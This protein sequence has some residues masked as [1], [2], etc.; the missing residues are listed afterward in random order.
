MWT[1]GAIR[2]IG[3]R[4]VI[5]AELLCQAVDIHAGERVLDVAAGSGNAALA[6]ARRGASVTAS[7]IAEAPL[8]L[9]RRRADLEGLALNTELADAQG[10]PF[11]DGSFDVVLSTFG[12]MFAPNQQRVADELTR[13][14]RPGGRIGL[15]N[16]TPRG[17][18]GSSFAM[19]DQHLPQ[20]TARL[21]RT[22]KWGTV[23]RLQ[24][25]LGDRVAELHTRRRSTD[26]CADS[27]AGLVT[28]LSTTSDPMRGVFD[29]L[30]QPRQARLAKDLATDLE[31]FNRAADGTFAAPAEYLEAIATRTC[32]HRA[33]AT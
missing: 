5:V 20:S 27:A 23:T 30:D 31:R 29:Q 8:E 28:S 16:W 19:I 25:L 4:H 12:V 24:K 3:V 10:L 2:Q 21:R 32:V 18:V 22:L 13:L 1:G 7:D 6:A 14:C 26:V 17:L 9:A 15:A 11:K 33:R